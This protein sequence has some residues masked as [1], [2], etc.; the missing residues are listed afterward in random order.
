MTKKKKAASTATHSLDL[1]NKDRQISQ[2][3]QLILVRKAFKD[4]PKTMRQVANELN[5]ER[6]NICWYVG[7]LRN[8]GQIEVHHQG[9]CEVT[10]HVVNYYTANVALFSSNGLQFSLFPEGG[11]E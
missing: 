7:M 1:Q 2:D 8:A 6:S 3:A 5:E 11:V 9:E 4:H 10:G